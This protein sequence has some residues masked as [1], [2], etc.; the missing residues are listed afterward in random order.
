MIHLQRRILMHFFIFG[1]PGLLCEFVHVHTE[2]VGTGIVC[3][4][5]V[6]MKKYLCKKILAYLILLSEIVPLILIC[7]GCNLADKL[8]RPHPPEK[9]TSKTSATEGI[10][11]F[12][13]LV[14]IDTT[15][16]TGPYHM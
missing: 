3:P 2:I 10:S 12:S 13:A 6:E 16:Q 7:G 11:D 8:A 1:I 4:C 5:Q 14:V 15:C 9:L